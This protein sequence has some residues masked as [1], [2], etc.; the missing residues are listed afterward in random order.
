MRFADMSF[1]GPGPQP[2][3]SGIPGVFIFFVVI[4]IGIGVVTTLVKVSQARRMAERS[5]MDPNEA[6][7]MTL[8]NPD[9]LAATY[10]A[11][12]LRPHEHD[13]APAPGKSTAE[14]LAELTALKESG[15]ITEAEYAERRTAIIGSI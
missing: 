7:A 9:G 11:S 4:V 14:R 10:L 15:A 12:N 13:A 3:G 6:T 2:G 8:L 1:S 5:G